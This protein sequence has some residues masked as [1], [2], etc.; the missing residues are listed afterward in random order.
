MLIKMTGKH[1]I[2]QR[3]LKVSKHIRELTISNNGKIYC[4][5]PDCLWSIKK[6]MQKNKTHRTQGK[7]KVVMVK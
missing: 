2:L 7:K 4:N 5:T 3:C 1:L 6:K